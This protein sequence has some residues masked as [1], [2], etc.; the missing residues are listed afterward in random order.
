MAKPIP[1]GFHTVTP[2]I[3]VS[4]SAKAIA[5]Y[6]KAFGAEE[7]G[8]HKTPDGKIM[9]AEIRIG[10]SVV[11]L[12]DEFPGMGPGP[13]SPD[14]LK[15]TTAVLHIYTPDVDAAFK[16]AVDA[17][18]GVIMPVADM[19]WGDRYAQ[20][21]DPFGHRWSIATRKEDVS[22]EE[23]VRRGEAFFKQMKK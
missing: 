17:G 1:E 22:A 19:F 2:S 12:N 8:V 14:T 11:M 5:F 7:R 10:D 9:H 13:R 6:K 18:A 20:V 3:V 23:A 15:G 4:D 21:T 16:R